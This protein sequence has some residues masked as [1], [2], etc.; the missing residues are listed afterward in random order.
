MENSLGFIGDIHGDFQ[1]L[2]TLIKKFNNV[3]FII[4][5]DCGF[6][7]SPLHKI[8]R[9]RKMNFDI[10]L[11]KQNIHLCFIRGNHDNPEWWT[12]ENITQELCTEYF[13]LVKD[14]TT[15]LIGGKSI[16]CIGGAVSIDRCLRKENVSYWKD[17]TLIPIPYSTL[18]KVDILCTHAIITDALT[19]GI[20]KDDTL[21]YYL[22]KDSNL[23]SDLYKEELLLQQI[24][25]MCKP[26]YWIHGHFHI[27][28]RSYYEGTNIISLNC[29]ELYEYKML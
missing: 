1:A 27:S 14:Y 20:L 2:H 18:N 25:F 28:N 22:K 7:F 9:M 6:G 12:N 15:I 19:Y 21:N 3:T 10:L 16:L 26:D 11:K 17:E 13:T 4:A 29:N 24:H 8:V 5:G 23:A